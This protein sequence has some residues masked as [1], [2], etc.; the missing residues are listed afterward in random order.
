[1][2]VNFTFL[3]NQLTP[4]LQFHLARFGNVML[5]LDQKVRGRKQLTIK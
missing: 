2:I 1:L 5:G 3:I 4:Q